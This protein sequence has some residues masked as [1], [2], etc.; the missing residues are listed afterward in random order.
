LTKLSAEC[1]FFDNSHRE[2]GRLS[3]DSEPMN[4]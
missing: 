2:N 1:L 3:A 4:M